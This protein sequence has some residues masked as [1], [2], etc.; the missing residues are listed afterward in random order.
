MSIMRR[1]KGLRGVSEHVK[2]SN[3]KGDIVVEYVFVPS[4]NAVVTTDEFDKL[5]KLRKK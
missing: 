4:L 1:R 3:N 2:T 5:Y